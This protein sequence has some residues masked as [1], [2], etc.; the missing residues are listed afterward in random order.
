[1]KRAIFQRKYQ[2]HLDQLVHGKQL[3]LLN[4]QPFW[5]WFV[6]GFGGRR[7]K[8][9]NAE[10]GPKM[11]TRNKDTCFFLSCTERLLTSVFGSYSLSLQYY[12]FKV[13]TMIAEQLQAMKWPW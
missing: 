3:R 9:N 1:M 2:L 12:L 8:V 5:T 11:I 7:G 10:D 13:D 4:C 6:I